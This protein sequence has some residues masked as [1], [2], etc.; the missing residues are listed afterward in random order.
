MF[1]NSI[2]GQRRS[3]NPAEPSPAIA[4]TAMGIAFAREGS[5]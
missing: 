4:K 1:R 2:L 5:S 3:T